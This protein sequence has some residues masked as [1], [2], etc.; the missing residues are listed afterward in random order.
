[1]RHPILARMKADGRTAVWLAGRTGYHAK[2]LSRVFHG[3]RPANPTLRAACAAE[4]G[5]PEAE[6]FHQGDSIARPTAGQ[7]RDGAAVAALSAD[8][9]P[10]STPQEAPLERTA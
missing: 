7:F 8:P 6:L 9:T 3:H 5:V 2:Y 1:V 10:L 4:L